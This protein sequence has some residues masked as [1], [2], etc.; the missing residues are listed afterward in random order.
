MDFNR[1]Q[2][3]SGKDAGPIAAIASPASG[4]DKTLG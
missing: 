2:R 4:E 3:G 1:G